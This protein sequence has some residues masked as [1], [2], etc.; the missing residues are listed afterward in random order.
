M[1]QIEDLKLPE[2]LDFYFESKQ[3]FSEMQKSWKEV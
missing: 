3:F 2:Y 1:S